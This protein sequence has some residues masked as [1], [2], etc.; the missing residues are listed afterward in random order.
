LC[1]FNIDSETLNANHFTRTPSFSM[2]SMMIA[3]MRWC[4]N[5]FSGMDYRKVAKLD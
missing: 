4:S 1:I 2:T 5:S 3:E